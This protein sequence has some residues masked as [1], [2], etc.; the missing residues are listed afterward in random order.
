MESPPDAGVADDADSSAPP[1]AESVEPL[2]D[3]E[4][5]SVDTSRWAGVQCHPDTVENDD[6]GCVPKS[7]APAIRCGSERVVRVTCDCAPSDLMCV[8]RCARMSKPHRYPHWLEPA[9]TRE[10]AD[11]R[12]QCQKGHA[13]SCAHLGLALVGADDRAKREGYDLLEKSCRL[14]YEEAC[15]RLYRSYEMSPE[16][17]SRSIAA[18]LEE[19]KCASSTT[20]EEACT[21]AA[22]AYDAGWG[23]PIDAAKAARYRERACAIAKAR[24][25]KAAQSYQRDPAQCLAFS[26]ACEPRR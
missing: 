12:R 11:C 16:A 5:V 25:Q 15:N 17:R 26:G 4:L 7:S 10:Y 23:V 1:A 3:V 18:R 2:T 21:R 22:R 6:R 20:N 8:M 24:C 14:G 13:P 9:P 19:S